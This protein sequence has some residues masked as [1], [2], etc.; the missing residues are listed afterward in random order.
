M[1][2]VVSTETAI[3]FP[4]F[5]LPVFP[6]GEMTE[7]IF[8]DRPL[9]L[10]TFIKDNCDASIFVID[11]LENFCRRVP[12]AGELIYLISQE[13]HADTGR[14]VRSRRISLPVAIDGPTFSL[15]SRLE[16]K[17]VPALYLVSSDRKI[18]KATVGFV[19]AEFEDLLRNL[20]R[21]NSLPETEPLESEH[22]IPPIKPG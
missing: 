3:F 17:T 1:R 15:S 19:K 2:S 14:L 16:F 18:V 7:A 21:A 10:V 5:H 12:E 6:A 13:D 20:M 8:R 4:E 22:A 9:S 11:L